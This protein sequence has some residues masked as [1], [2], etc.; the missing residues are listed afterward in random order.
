MTPRDAA[1]AL[2]D[3]ARE[4]DLVV[5]RIE[6][7]APDLGVAERSRERT[8]RDLEQLRDRVEQLARALE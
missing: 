4:L 1:R 3:L 6:R 2:E 5:Y 7:P 8:R